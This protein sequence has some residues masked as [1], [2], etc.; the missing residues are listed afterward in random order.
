[1]PIGPHD[2]VSV[3]I[4]LLPVDQGVSIRSTSVIVERRIQL[5]DQTPG[6]S[7]S[8]SIPQS[9][10]TLRPTTSFY[11]QTPIPCSKVSY[12]PTAPSQEEP[13]FDESSST[14]SLSSSTPTIV[15]DTALSSSLTIAS[16]S[17]PLLHPSSS[18]LTKLVVNPI[19]GTESS[20]GLFRDE[21]GVWSRTLTLQWPAV[22][23]HS[24][25]AVGE[26]I[27]SDLVTVKYFVRS[28]VCFFPFQFNPPS[29]LQI[30]DRCVFSIWYR[31]NR[32]RRTG[33]PG[34]IYQ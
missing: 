28:K 6:A 9:P 24:L 14:P 2:L 12:S 11:K 17:T 25:W 16:E 23:S 10:I 15:P 19:A 26:T 29:N 27:S 21:N 4:H 5:H 1:M 30:P 32:P 33:T 20:A 22:K 7:G 18:T 31:V 3:S 8:T 13:Q 34:G